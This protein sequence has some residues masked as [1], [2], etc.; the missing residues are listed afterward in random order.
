MID[1][2]LTNSHQIGMNDDDKTEIASVYHSYFDRLM[3]H[4]NE[5]PFIQLTNLLQNWKSRPELAREQ[6]KLHDI[7]EE[8]LYNYLYQNNVTE[9]NN[10]Q[11]N[12][13]LL[14]NINTIFNKQ[15]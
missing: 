5:N 11:G 1:N 8:W 4:N 9:Y 2:L 15:N 6:L 10:K 14:P 3:Q 12:K 13:V 7:L